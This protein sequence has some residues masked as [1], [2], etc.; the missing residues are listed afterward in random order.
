MFSLP[1]F[2]DLHYYLLN[3]PVDVGQQL[4]NLYVA[5][6]LA[7]VTLLCRM[8]SLASVPKY[9]PNCTVLFILLNLLI[10]LQ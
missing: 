1:V 7:Q 8:I 2:S 3:K 6:I 10:I 4:Q 9:R 5:P